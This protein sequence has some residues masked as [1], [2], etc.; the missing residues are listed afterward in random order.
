MAA[1]PYV[2]KVVY[3]N[4][5]LIDL[6][7]DDVTPED[8]ADGVYFHNASGERKMGVYVAP[9]VNNAK[10][11]I[12]KNGTTI[13]TFTANSATDTTINI[14][15]PTKASDINAQAAGTYVTSDAARKITAGT[16]APSGG[17]N[18]DIYIQYT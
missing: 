3:G 2:N 14:T 4:Q 18:G 7:N 5:T 1:N 6:T 8:V 17:S 10:L 13:N 12:Q 11:T 9:T 16:A 15:V